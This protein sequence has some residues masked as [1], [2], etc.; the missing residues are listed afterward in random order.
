M[1][2]QE[3]ETDLEEDDKYFDFSFRIY[4]LLI[5]DG[6]KD[7]EK[8][9]GIFYSNLNIKENT[10]MDN[11]LCY[12][13]HINS[14]RIE[15]LI[16]FLNEWEKMF[17]SQKKIIL[18]QDKI[19][20]KKSIFNDGDYET[21]IKLI[22]K[23]FVD[24]IV[25]EYRNN[26]EEIPFVSETSLEYMYYSE[27]LKIKDITQK[28]FLRN[29]KNVYIQYESFVTLYVSDNYKLKKKYVFIYIP[30]DKILFEI[31]KQ[32]RKN[33]YKN[34]IELSNKENY[35][36]NILNFEK[37]HQEILNN[38]FKLIVMAFMGDFFANFPQKL[39]IDYMIMPQLK[40]YKLLVEFFISNDFKF[41]KYDKIYI[42]AF[43]MAIK[44]IY[45][46][47]LDELKPKTIFIYKYN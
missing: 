15:L 5:N 9:F 4:D 22:F 32:E 20:L 29:F 42:Q 25:L 21:K 14:S 18:E 30:F 45:A 11:T 12:I 24:Y 8:I 41:T 28:V 47:L 37:M 31:L 26:N 46:T 19:L 38:N 13:K 16:R 6:I 33:N 1:D 10:L 36:T 27:F 35:N 7:F 40:R 43:E 23:H 34:L 2:I 17:K 44:K 39:D 3:H